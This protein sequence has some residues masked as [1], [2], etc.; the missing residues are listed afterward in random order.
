MWQHVGME[1][2]DFQIPTYQWDTGAPIDVLRTGSLPHMLLYALNEL[3]YVYRGVGESDT[4]RQ[5][6]V[7]YKILKVASLHCT[8]QHSSQKKES[9]TLGAAYP[10]VNLSDTDGLEHLT[11]A[12]YDGVYMPGDPLDLIGHHDW[13]SIIV[14]T[15]LH[16]IYCGRTSDEHC[17]PSTVASLNAEQA[18]KLTWQQGLLQPGKRR[19]Q[20]TPVAAV[21][22]PTIQSVVNVPP[23][24]VS[25]H[26]T[27]E[28]KPCHSTIKRILTGR[29]LSMRPADVL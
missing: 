2:A 24:A 5:C 12:V 23:Q 4:D 18:T 26:S 19:P 6:T 1:I 14:G 16:L 8:E 13:E 15:T 11:W 9:N 3:F 7:V 22:T 27:G 28:H 29:A 21:Q 25:S 17:K 10:R 20:A